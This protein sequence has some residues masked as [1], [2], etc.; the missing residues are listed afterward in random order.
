MIQMISDTTYTIMML[1]A[2]LYVFLSNPMIRRIMRQRST[3]KY[4]CPPPC[5]LGKE[6]LL[7]VIP[8][9]KRRIVESQ[10]F[11]CDETRSNAKASLAPA[12]QTFSKW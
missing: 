7:L 9:E 11:L 10:K 5:L 8:R 1:A 12:L 6:M 4:P 3:G 2:L